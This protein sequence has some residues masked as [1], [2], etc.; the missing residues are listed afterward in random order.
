[1]CN[2]VCCCQRR[3]CKEQFYQQTDPPEC[4][5]CKICFY[6]QTDSFLAKLICYATHC[7]GD[8]THIDKDFTSIDQPSN[9]QI[10]IF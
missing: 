2:C 4:V 3:L 10:V 8:L 1:M 5:L 9:I 7:L 6:C